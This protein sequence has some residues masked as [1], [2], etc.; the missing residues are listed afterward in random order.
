MQR[1]LLCVS[2][3]ALAAPALAQ[4]TLVIPAAAATVDG[5]SSTSWPFDIA[6]GRFIYIY[7]STHFSNN[8]VTFPVLISQIRV[9][10]NA[11]T[12]TWTGS[13][14]TLQMDLSTAPIDYTAISTTWNNNHGADRA[15][16]YNGAWSI[17][18]GSST[19]GVPGPF[20]ATVTFSQPFL[21]DPSLGDLTIDT[22]HSGITTANTPTLDAVTTVGVANAKRVYST[23]NP[24][25]ATATLWSGDLANV[26]EFTYVPAAG[27]Y[28]AFSATPTSG[29]S[30]LSVQFTDQSY[31]SVPGGVIGWAWDL[32]GDTV[33]DST[34]QNPTW[35]YGCGTYNVTLTV[36]DAQNPPATLTKTGYIVVDAIAAN[37]TASPLGGFAPVTVNFT[38]T[39]TGPVTGWSWDLD[40]DNIPDTTLQNP[41]WIY[42]A[43]G[44]YTVSLTVT[45][46][47]RTSTRTR[48]NLITVLLPGQLPP[49]AELLQYQFNEVR[50]TELGNSA[51]TNAA[52]SQA[53]MNATNWWSDPGR[54]G[55]R[56]NEPGRGCLGYRATG[57][58]Y[59]NTGWPTSITGSLSISFWLMR[60]LASTGTNPFGYVFGNSTF[61]SFCA[62][63][64]GQGITFRG[65]ALTVD[66][67]F[68]VI[69]TPGVWQHLTLVVDDNAGQALWYDNGV[70]STNVVTFAPNTFSYVSTVNLAVGAYNISGTSPIGTHYHLDDFRFYTR[71]LSPA[72]IL[73]NALSV[74]QASAGVSGLSCPG[75]LG[76]PVIGSTGGAPTQGNAAFAVTLSNAEDLRLAA[77]AFGFTPAAFGT[78]DLSPWLGAGCVLQNDAVGLNFLIT[79]GNAATQPF[80]IPA[81]GFAGLHIYGQWAVLGT[82]GAATRMIDINIQ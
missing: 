63:A 16:V 36:V 44:Q 15:T 27:L 14:A 75:T 7:D 25:A 38:D 56:G 26:L 74:E 66:S 81:A 37:F 11:A 78:F 71:A 4:F 24:P 72:E 10:A 33:G 13:T 6:T 23:T 32:D 18:A 70:P 28:P 64:A 22:T 62:G 30:P 3:A 52:P 39:S 17:P 34:A 46:S 54:P 69:N 1:T 45:S 47:C 29:N 42:G 8:G 73:I 77:I 21:Y 61:R 82:V 48:T 51:S 57:A 55:F 43:P 58:G 49:P 19:A 9:R 2:L 35:V 80:P 79:S 20:Y 65:T 67:V 50:G 59:A 40:G 68:P 12:A 5:N 60:D 31:S 41:S 76:T 53:T